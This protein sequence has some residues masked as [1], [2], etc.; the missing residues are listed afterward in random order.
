MSA[1]AVIDSL[2]CARGGK[3]LRGSVPVARLERLHDGL[4]DSGGELSYVVRG[5][6]DARQRP[7]LTLEVRGALHLQCQRCLGPLEFPIEV[8]SAFLL[9]PKGGEEPDDAADPESPDWIEASPE[10]DLLELVEDEVLLAVPFAPRHPEGGCG[11]A[12]EGATA[13][14][15]SNAFAALAAL[16]NSGNTR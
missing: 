8:S 12:P 11:G 13:G 1:A 3:E 2:A 5:G 15:R 7:M 6:K 4:S 14:S 16:K 10:L 9:V